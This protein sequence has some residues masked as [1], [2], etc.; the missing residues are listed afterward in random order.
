MNTFKNTSTAPSSSLGAMRLV[1]AVEGKTEGTVRT[2][3]DKEKRP[4]RA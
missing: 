1:H 2:S 3:T 4:K